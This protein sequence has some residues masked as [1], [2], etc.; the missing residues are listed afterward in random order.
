MVR[1]R[2]Y[3]A[4]VY[5][6]IA[7]VVVTIAALVAAG[8]AYGSGYIQTIDLGVPSQWS[9]CESDNQCVK[10]PNSCGDWSV[11]RQFL[12]KAEMLIINCTK[13][14]PRSS[15]SLPR[16]ISNKCVLEFSADMSAAHLNSPS[17]G[18]QPPP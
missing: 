1:H 13:S 11:N 2:E 8:C 6:T 7:G 12:D 18:T 4:A 17:R 14:L 10:V 15:D 16:C 3:L 5:N 9:A